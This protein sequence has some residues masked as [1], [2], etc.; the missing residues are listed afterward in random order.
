MKTQYTVHAVIEGFDFTVC[1]HKKMGFYLKMKPK[2]EEVV[3]YDDYESAQS[4]V[5]NYSGM[6]KYEVVP[7]EIPA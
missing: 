5:D 7:V 2:D 1:Y 3:A 6:I 4:L